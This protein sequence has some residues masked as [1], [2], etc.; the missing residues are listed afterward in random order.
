MSELIAVLPELRIAIFV[1]LAAI[2]AGAMVVS[3]MRMLAT[4]RARL[5][6]IALFA[7]SFAGV[8][9]CYLRHLN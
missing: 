3:T 4:P 6:F 5:L 9:T 1:L 7:V 8:A 2:M